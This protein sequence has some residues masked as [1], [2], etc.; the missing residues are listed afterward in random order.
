MAWNNTQ[1]GV[2]LNDG[3][4]KLRDLYTT[5]IPQSRNALQNLANRSIKG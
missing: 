5:W 2:N 1:E 3:W 4:E